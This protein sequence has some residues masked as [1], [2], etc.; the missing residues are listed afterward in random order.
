MRKL[1]ITLMTS[2][3]VALPAFAL[4]DIVETEKATF[5]GG[6]FWCV[7]SDFQDVDGVVSAVSGFTGGTLKNPTYRG[8][9]KGHYEAVEIE[10]DPAIISY[11]E[12]LKR[13]WRSIDPFDSRGQFCDK[14]FEYQSAIFAHDDEQ[15]QLA[16]TTMAEVAARFPE[17]QIATKILDS[18][19]FWPVEEYHQDYYLKKPIR[20]KYYRNGCGRDKRVKQIWG[21]QAISAH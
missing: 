5:A 10:F 18:N 3:I 9:H 13:Y 12:L 6:C 19:Q 7:E 8:N 20:Y 21:E 17:Q 1:L 2:V 4:A 16:E 11:A 14:G 15:K